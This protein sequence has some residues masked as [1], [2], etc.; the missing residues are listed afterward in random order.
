MRLSLNPDNPAE[1]VA[2]MSG[3]APTPV[4]LAFFGLGYARCVIAGV[5]LGLFDAL[6]ESPMEVE[7]LAEATGCEAEGLRPLL[8]A[9]NGFGLLKHRRGRYSCGVLARRWL[10]RDSPRSM[11]ELVLLIGDLAPRLE[12][13]ERAA[14]GDPLPRLHDSPQDPEFWPRYV[15]ALGLAA[16][17][18]G[19][20]LARRL[21]LPQAP[22]RLLDVGGGHGQFA[23]ALCRRYP[24]LTAE[25]LEL[26]EVVPH[27]EAM[28]SEA[29]CDRV[30][31]RA[32]DMRADDWGEGYDLITLFNVLHN[33][34]EA[35]AIDAVRRAYAALAPGGTLAILDA[36]HQTPTGDRSATAGFNELFFALISGAGAWPEE[37][38]RGWM[39]DAGFVHLQ[40]KR[41]WTMPEV[42]LTGRRAARGITG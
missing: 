27:G 12:A 2:L 9:L 34:T 7:A 19:P 32:G 1:R 36:E 26:P 3:L 41:L 11:S 38:M 31:Y 37:T 6:G 5:R 10:R 15:R 17:W 39:R 4:A 42:L 22:A 28:V 18:V 23:V 14:R 16:R 33:A 13:M 40:R 29:G 21:P 30:R 24:G 35:E 25:V 8:A 20:E